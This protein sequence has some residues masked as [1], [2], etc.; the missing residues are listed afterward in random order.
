MNVNLI[1]YI[2]N[3]HESNGMIRRMRTERESKC[4]VCVQPG[5]LWLL[6]QGK[7]L[8]YQG[9]ACEEIRI[10]CDLLTA[11]HRL[12]ND[13]FDN[14]SRIQISEDARNAPAH[15]YVVVTLRPTY[16]KKGTPRW[17]VR[18]ERRRRE[19]PS[20]PKRA[21]EL[22]APPLDLSPMELLAIHDSANR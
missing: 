8:H 16:L 15:K 10:H 5:M 9:C 22:Q 21:K 2:V 13:E 20:S 14:D 4:P 18:V 7:W 12:K 19:D 3:L 1:V 11:G 17:I 6:G